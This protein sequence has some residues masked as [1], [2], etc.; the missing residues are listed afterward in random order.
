MSP[1]KP[2]QGPTPQL[3]PLDDTD[4]G[5]ELYPGSY[6]G[7]FMP[8]TKNEEPWSSASSAGSTSPGEW[9]FPREARRVVVGGARDAHDTPCDVAIPGRGLSA[10]HFMLERRAS[11]FRLYD[12]GST[13]GTYVGNERVVGSWD[14]RLGDKFCARP[15]TFFV[16][17]ETMRKHRHELPEILGLYDSFLPTPDMLLTELVRQATPVV[18]TGDAGSGQERLA[19]AIHEMSPRS[20]RPIVQISETPADRAAQIA[21][22]T[23]VSKGTVVLMIKAKRAAA[24][25][26][27]EFLSALYSSSYGVRVIA[28]APTVEDAI[29][30][31]GSKYFYYSYL[32]KLQPLKFRI[33][34]IPQLLDRMFIARGAAKLRTGDLLKINQEA[35]RNHD[36]ASLEQL[37][38]LADTI[39]AHE[40]H[41]G[42]RPAAR[43]LGVAH[44]TLDARLTR[45]G[46]SSRK[47]AD[48]RDSLFKP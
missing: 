38:K 30:G 26:D 16:M 17:D 23:K 32:I 48:G 21:V 37:N 19:Q 14:V 12:L 22:A 31:L 40:R 29:H 8:R 27:P 34:E 2:A 4:A 6:I 24:P 15:S 41:G 9:S 35:L 20:T 7:E 45:V 11:C 5:V 39:V 25:I 1:A 28:L 10:T 13:N 33:E 42:V 46:L 47:G 3:P 36:W 18:I 44:N 43:G